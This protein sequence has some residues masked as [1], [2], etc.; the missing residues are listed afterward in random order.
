M[1]RIPETIASLAAL[2]LFGC[3]PVARG[4]GQLETRELGLSDFTRLELSHA[5]EAVV[6]R[7]DA[8]GVEVSL[9]DNL[10]PFLR[11]EV[12][13]G[14][15]R[16]G[17]EPGR[18]YRTEP[19]HM[20]VRVRLPRLAAL[21]ASGA[22]RVELL[23]FGEAPAAELLRLHLSGASRIEGALQADRLLLDASGASGFALT[24]RA[25]RLEAEASG[26]SRLELARLR[27]GSAEVSLSGASQA[28]VEVLGELEIDASGASS[29]VYHG[30]P[31]LGRVHTS[32][33]SSL[34]HA[35]GP[36]PALPAEAP[37]GRGDHPAIPA[38][39]ALQAVR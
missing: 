35:G 7:S 1:P 34:R 37:P 27:A 22:C 12:H 4:S 26:A 16:I 20:R 31:R 3:L 21:E 2:A 5:F 19:G 9:D 30:Q 13:Q 38:V 10:M 18:S 33:A 36:A 14:A 6:E 32:G 28:E 29:L 17:L 25:E 15:L 23:G 8:F 39:P 24:G 11:A